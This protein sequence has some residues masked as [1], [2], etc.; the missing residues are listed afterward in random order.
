MLVYA[1]VAMPCSI[2]LFAKT[3]SPWLSPITIAIPFFLW[4]VLSSLIDNAQ[5]PYRDYAKRMEAI[6]RFMRLQDRPIQAAAILRHAI[7]AVVHTQGPKSG[8]GRLLRAQ[9]A[10]IEGDE[11]SRCVLLREL[12]DSSME[13]STAMVGLFSRRKKLGKSSRERRDRLLIDAALCLFPPPDTGDPHA[14]LESL[15]FAYSSLLSR[16]HKAKE[17]KEI[18]DFCLEPDFRRLLERIRDPLDPHLPGSP[19]LDAMSALEAPNGSIPVQSTIDRARAMGE[20]AAVLRELIVK[21]EAR[22]DGDDDDDDDGD[23]EEEDDDDGDDSPA[24]L[25]MPCCC[26]LLLGIIGI[27]L[28]APVL[29]SIYVWPGTQ[30]AKDNLWHLFQAGYVMGSLAAGLSV[31]IAGFLC[32]GCSAILIEP[33][34]ERLLYQARMTEMDQ[35]LGDEEASECTVFLVTLYLVGMVGAVG[36]PFTAI[37]LNWTNPDDDVSTYFLIAAT[38]EIIMV[39]L[40]IKYGVDDTEGEGEGDGAAAT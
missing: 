15:V 22:G 19:L 7:A 27:E 10:V 34:V 20:S 17:W 31:P 33:S 30:Q 9:L 13:G 39:F 2:I 23:E 14:M 8:R 37:V 6:A 18:S 40:W 11:D 36:I 28:A 25:A 24:R 21:T 4:G 5:G 35:D 32:Y 26:L 38:V 1:T 3:G 29:L 16:L 12:N